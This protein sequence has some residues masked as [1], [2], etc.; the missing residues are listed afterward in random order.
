MGPKNKKTKTKQQQQKKIKITGWLCFRAQLRDNAGHTGTESSGCFRPRL[1]PSCE[2]FKFQ[3][4]FNLAIYLCIHLISFI[5]TGKTEHKISQYADDTEIML[6]G[7][8][9]SFERTVKIIDTSGK[10][11]RSLLECGEDHC[12]MA[13]W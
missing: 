5:S 3:S 12:H 6:E 8:R 9:N 1:R 13:R 10:K 2:R 7:N 11:I 4:N